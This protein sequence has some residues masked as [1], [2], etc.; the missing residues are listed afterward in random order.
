MGLRSQAHTLL[1]TYRGE[2][3]ANAVSRL[4]EPALAI[5]V[6]TTNFKRELKLRG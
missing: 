6:A 4:D 3:N 1:D 2:L 5:K